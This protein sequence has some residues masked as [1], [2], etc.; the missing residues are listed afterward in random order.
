MIKNNFTIEF[1]NFYYDR[2]LLVKEINNSDNRTKVKDLKKI[3]NEVLN[4]V[5]S[6]ENR[7]FSGLQAKLLYCK[8]KFNIDNDF[9]F[10]LNQASLF[11]SKSSRSKNFKVYDTQVAFLIKVICNFINLFSG[12][13]IPPEIE[14]LQS[15]DYLF[16]FSEKIELKTDEPI[17]VLVKN[18][19]SSNSTIEMQCLV[20]ESDE[21]IIININK[22]SS[23]DDQYFNYVSNIPN[24]TKIYFYKLEKS[25]FNENVFNTKITD[26]FVIEPDFLID[27]S[28]IAGCFVNRD[29]N[30]KIFFL[31][32]F[33]ASGS[34]ASTIRGNIVNNILDLSII[35]S[36]KDFEYLFEKAAEK[37]LM[38]ISLL[39]NSEFEGIKN[40][41]ENN[42]YPQIK[43]ITEFLL[44]VKKEQNADIVI[45]PTFYSE[46]HGLQGRLDI[47]IQF[48]NDLERK[49][50]IELK[51]GSPARFGVWENE[52][53]QAVGYD[54]ILQSVFGS[55]RT[56]SNNIMYSKENNNTFRNVIRGYNEEINFCKIRN[57]IICE[58][59]NQANGNF[60]LY[61]SFNQRDFGAIPKYSTDKLNTFY[62]VYKSS[63]L[64]SLKYFKTY[65]AFIWNEIIAVKLGNRINSDFE[66]LGFSSLW[67]SSI[68][69]KKERFQIIDLI[70]FEF[71][72]DTHKL[73]KFN[74]DDNINNFRKNDIAI[75]YKYTGDDT[76]P[77]KQQ[78]YKCT[79]EDISTNYVVISL[80]NEQPAKDIFI[81][82]EKY[83]IEHDLFDKNLYGLISSLFNFLSQDINKREIL[84]GTKLPA[85]NYIDNNETDYINYYLQK[86][87]N[88]NNYFLLQGPPGTG[89][90]STFL[91]NYVKHLYDNTDLQIMIVTFTNRSLLEIIKHLLNNNLPF[92]LVASGNDEKYSFKTILK[93]NKF[94]E[95]PFA[96]FRICLSTISSYILY[97]NEIKYHFNVN[98]LI[99][100]E[101]SQISEVQI[102]GVL[103]D[104]EKFVMIG[105]HNQL[106]AI[107]VQS[108]EFCLIDD[109]EL[110]KIELYNLKDSY[111]ERLYNICE[112]K[113][114]KSNIDLLTVHYRLHEEIAGL[115]NK[116][117]NNKLKAG[118][119]RQK[120]P[121]VEF[122][123]V[124]VLGNKPFNKRVIFIN[125]KNKTNNLGY[126]CY[127]EAE[128]IRNI[129]EQLS[130]KCKT[131][132]DETFGVITPF[133]AQISVIRNLLKDLSFYNK[134]QIDTV[135]RYQGSEKDIIFISFGVNNKIQ[136][137][138]LASYNSSKTVDRKLNVALSRA[139]EYLVLIGNEKI[140][141]QHLPL[142]Q[143][144]ETIKTNYSY[145]EINNF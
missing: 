83:C 100:D 4:L 99:I 75:I 22:V 94:K 122:N 41:I 117:Y 112:K 123:D 66:E 14:Q 98:T 134:I 37:S 60:S 59:L 125:V 105:D 139:K 92:V 145:I 120:L 19:T 63:D 132:D 116:Y 86:A 32:K 79:I 5:L 7:T 67:L 36:E 114:L 137:K 44:K 126:T 77:L 97:K 130:A 121:G 21:E 24:Y 15:V 40:E 10:K 81:K 82:T 138:G 55:N 109:E 31:D 91:V 47:L 16:K 104:F 52:K 57:L 48:L 26:Y 51:S 102:I 110:N 20:V 118:V 25:L 93:E 73:Y 3:F 136:I 84:M 127:E 18:V 107:S 1:A 133:R 33:F 13:N 8:D 119:E 101:A 89:K 50:I 71:Y 49:E 103:A 128:I 54:L 88:A 74:F 46:L 53:M 45:E 141:K 143:I 6:E 69:E 28:D 106:P 56:G 61:E 2:C 90:T 30:F 113:E 72:D 142:K 76:N 131:I 43:K 23:N 144:I 34:S 62:S 9:Y 111:F 17:K 115:I 108:D 129:I 135:E 70:E 65:L 58:I 85:Q 64:V 140:L 124:E 80:R 38:P 95:N 68:E 11:I 35:E 42:H 78:I 27:V 39:K 96:D 87:I 12:V 29:S